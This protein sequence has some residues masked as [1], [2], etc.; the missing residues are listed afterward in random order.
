M[1]PK[2]ALLEYKK[3]VDVELERY[4]KGKI[5]E[6]ENISEFSGRF[7]RHLTEYTLR[8]G[9]RLRAALIYY[10]YKLFGGEDEESLEQNQK[11]FNC[12]N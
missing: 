7:T 3:K 4:L 8:G 11:K 12:V 9:K 1:E 5:T 6:Y 10:S 2:T